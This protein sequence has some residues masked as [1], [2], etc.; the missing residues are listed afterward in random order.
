MEFNLKATEQTGTVESNSLL[1]YAY[2]GTQGWYEFKPDVVESAT[3]IGVLFAQELSYALENE[4]PIGIISCS[5]GASRIDDWVH[6]DYCFCEEYDF[7]N[8]AHSDYT[9][10]DQGH[11]DLYRNQIQPIEKLTT[12]GVL[13][14]QGESNRGAGEAYR[15]LDMFKTFVECWR[16]RMDDPTLPFYTVQ[17]M[18]YGSNN[19]KDMLGNPSDEF[20]I[21]I[22]QGEAARTMDGVTVCTMLSYEDTLA[23]NGTLDIHPTDK[24]PVAKALANAV[25]TTYYNP[26]GDY[27]K[28]P[29][30]SGPLYKEISV[31]GGKATITFNHIAEGLMLT[32]GSTINDLEVRNADGS[33]V[34]ATGTL[35]GN[36]VTVTAEGVSEITGVRMGYM[37][38]PDINLYSIIGGQRGYC[39][40]P[41]KWIAE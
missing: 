19:G 28:T 25:L 39:A 22:A 18:L 20:N 14:Y 6:E 37:N 2:R 32:K 26:L 24:L 40:S 8:T 23:A 41:F 30:Y 34:A 5:K 31:S 36:V 17:I 11:H 33:W 38:R 9:K 35:S 4:I 27:D 7:D 21:R 1:R 3:A 16:T 15:Y 12:A 29:E 13:W 10:Y